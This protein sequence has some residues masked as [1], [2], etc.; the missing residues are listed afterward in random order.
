L[1]RVTGEAVVQL[2][3]RFLQLKTKQ[4]AQST[5]EA[6]DEGVERSVQLEWSPQSLPNQL[7]TFNFAGR[8]ETEPWRTEHGQASEMV[9]CTQHEIIGTISVKS[10]SVRDNVLKLVID[11]TNTTALPIFHCGSPIRVQHVAFIQHC[12]GD[13]DRK[14]T[15]HDFAPAVMPS[16]RSTTCSHVAKP[17]CDLNS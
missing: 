11:V 12:V 3:L 9:R 1:L 7:S 15:I 8:F 6:W 16:M 10:E 5:L 17:W 14:L 4:L 2:E 13:F